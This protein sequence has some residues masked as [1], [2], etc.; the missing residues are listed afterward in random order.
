MLELSVLT[1]N[2]AI[3]L[4]PYVNRPGKGPLWRSNGTVREIGEATRKNDVRRSVCA[5][6]DGLQLAG[7]NQAKNPVSRYTSDRNK[8]F[9]RIARTG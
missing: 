8:R 2:S 9:F 3:C 7:M 5:Q 1:Q 6:I 4:R